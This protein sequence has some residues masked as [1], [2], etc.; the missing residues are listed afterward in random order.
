MNLFTNRLTD[1]ENEPMG[2]RGKDGGEGLVRKFGIA[3]VHTAIFKMGNQQ[4]PVG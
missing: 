2:T 3:I 1:L 4:G